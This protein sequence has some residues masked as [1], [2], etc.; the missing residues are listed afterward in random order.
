MGPSSDSREEVN[1]DDTPKS[2]SLPSPPRDPLASPLSQEVTARA[3]P[4][5]WPPHSS[6]QS[7]L[8]GAVMAT[9]VTQLL[10]CWL[11]ASPMLM[12][13]SACRG[14]CLINRTLSSDRQLDKTMELQVAEQ[15]SK[16]WSLSRYPGT[17]P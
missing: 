5:F 11:V 10:N 14:T 3:L 2:S 17:L 9:T 6:I 12:P 13:T 16:Q 1:E 7:I 15:G 8:E 4:T